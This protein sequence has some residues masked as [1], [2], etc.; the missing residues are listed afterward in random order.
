[1]NSEEK[2][3]N[4]CMCKAGEKLLR[5]ELAASAL[6]GENF[7]RVIGSFIEIKRKFD[8]RRECENL[9]EIKFGGNRSKFREISIKS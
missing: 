4:E 2:N 5:E 9:N 1:M 8:N 6:L 7:L 3:I